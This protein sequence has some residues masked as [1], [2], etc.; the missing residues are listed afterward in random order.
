VPV[1]Q[2]PLRPRPLLQVL[3]L[4]W[5]CLLPWLALQLPLLACPQPFLLRWRLVVAACSRRRCPR[6]RRCRRCDLSG[7]A[8]RARWLFRRLCRLRPL[9]DPCPLR[10]PLH[11]L[12]EAPLAQALLVLLLVLEQPL[13]PPLPLPLPLWARLC[14]QELL[15]L[16]R[17]A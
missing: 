4:R 8:S 5:P 12:L 7:L 15:A 13:R 9:A 14:R 17:V 11:L 10:L 3:A 16:R 6:P 2:Q 1:P